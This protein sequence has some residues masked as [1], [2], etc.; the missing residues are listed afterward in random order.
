MSEENKRLPTIDEA[1]VIA[2][3]LASNVKPKLKE[4]EEAMFIAGFQECIKFLV[5]KDIGG[6]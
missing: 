4:S 3:N 5:L 2:L 1:G 6:N